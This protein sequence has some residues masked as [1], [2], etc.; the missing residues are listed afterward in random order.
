[1]K[2]WLY[3][4]DHEGSDN[5]EA[6]VSW[7]GKNKAVQEQRPQGYGGVNN[8]VADNVVIYH[9]HSVDNQKACEV[10]CQI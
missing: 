1:M 2:E 9:A 4:L 5:A 7:H 6:D 8:V 10:G 3:A